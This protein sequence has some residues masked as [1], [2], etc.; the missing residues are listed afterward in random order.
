MISKEK[1]LIILTVFVD[2]LGFGI[3]VPILPFYVTSFGVSATTV[4]LLFAVFAFFS[5]LSTP[6][7]GAL[8]DKIGRR[9]I[10]IV[11]ILSTSIGWFVFAGAGSVI[12]LFIG[13]IVDGLAAGNISTAQSYLIDISKTDKERTQNLGV[14]S[15]IFGVGFIIGP[16]IGGFLSTISH[17]FPFW[18][19]GGLAMLNALLVFLFL[20][21]SRKNT[22]DNEEKISINPFKPL[23]RA[24][25][26]KALM[27]SFIAWFFFILAATTT[28]SM[29]SLFLK[30]N[31][32]FDAFKAGLVITGMGII[33][34]LNQT[35][36]LKHLWLKYF[37]EPDLVLLLVIIM[38]AGLLL[39]GSTVNILFP[40]GLIFVSFC[41]SVLRVV[42]TSQ[43]A[44]KAGPEIRGEILGIMTSIASLSMVIGPLMAGP[45]FEI[46]TNIPFLTGFIYTLIV[47]AVIYID[48]KSL[49]KE[50]LP[51]DVQTD[52]M[53]Y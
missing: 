33:I 39:M 28:Q 29:L 26:N 31:F 2:I 43:M 22:N 8:S 25:K 4:T 34:A 20:P 36:G 6:F 45:L 50:E 14:I 1:G 23:A 27:P 44:G 5:F 9:P 32:G 38:G 7:L 52:Q 16:M 41:Q 3:I 53:V 11:S 21:E 51:E 15:A 13:R 19:V 35:I 37:K 10:L 24:I 49:K 48:R 18:F 40:L 47:L 17:T 46:K 30:D 12:W 42:M